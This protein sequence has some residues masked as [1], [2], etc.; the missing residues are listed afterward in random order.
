M[1][2]RATKQTPCQSAK[3]RVLKGETGFCHDSMVLRR[4]QRCMAAV[5]WETAKNTPAVFVNESFGSL[6]LPLH[7]Q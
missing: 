2:S 5:V 4:Q 6:V 1:D 7:L 3:P